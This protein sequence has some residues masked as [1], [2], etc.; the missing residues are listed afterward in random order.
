MLRSVHSSPQARKTIPYS[1]LSLPGYRFPGLRN[2]G[3]VGRGPSSNQQDIL[4]RRSRDH[5]ES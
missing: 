5:E 4:L 1:L 3:L 2:Q